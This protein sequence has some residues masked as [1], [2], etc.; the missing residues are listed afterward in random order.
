[1]GL[2]TYPLADTGS[3][4]TCPQTQQREILPEPGVFG[5]DVL[6]DGTLHTASFAFK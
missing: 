3:R 5:L 2:E 1:M 6:D 4:P